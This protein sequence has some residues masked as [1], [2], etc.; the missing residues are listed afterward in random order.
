VIVGGLVAFTTAFG[1]GALLVGKVTN[2]AK[3]V[4]LRRQSPLEV[5]LDLIIARR[6]TAMEICGRDGRMLAAR[7]EQRN[8]MTKDDKNGVMLP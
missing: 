3:E 4:L 2:L 8:G 7:V 5:S 6:A 1:L